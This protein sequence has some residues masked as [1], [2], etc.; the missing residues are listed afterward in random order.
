LAW[1]ASWPGA[2]WTVPV[3]PGWDQA[4]GIAAAILLV[5][6]LPWRLR[7]LALPL[8][9]PLLMPPPTWPEAGQFEVVAVDVGQ[10]TSVLVRTH[11]HLLV[12]DAGPQYS[13]DSDAGQ[14][15][16]LPLLRS[17]GEPRIDRLMLS[18]RDNDHVGGARALLQGLP[19]TDMWSSLEDGHPLLALAKDPSRCHAGQSWQ[20]DGVRFDVL[21]PDAIAYDAGLKSNAMSCVLRV[22]S[23]R[24]GSLL[25]TGDIEREQEAALVAALGDALR[26][27][28]LVVPHHGSKTSSTGPFLDAA[29]PRV[30]VFQSGYRNRFGHPA[31]EVLARYTERHITVFAS[32]SCGAWSWPAGVAGQGVCQRDAA[33]RYWHH[34]AE[35]LKET[36]GR[37]QVSLTPSGG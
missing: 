20:W 32:P 15:V 13:R 26:S 24:S 4:A 2:V 35:A 29:R 7:A 8:S 3:A 25:L 10:G 27:D 9:L 30:A 18:H 36:P 21:Q 17:R 37:S 11:S 1:L 34:A 31:P 16:L 19:V 5:L 23:E 22:S 6:P 14:R 28:L 33:R 12:Y